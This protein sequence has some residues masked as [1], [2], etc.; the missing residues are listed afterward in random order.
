MTKLSESKGFS[1]IEL[2]TVIAI[3]AI[4][5]AIIFPVMNSVKDRANQTKCMTN[6]HDIQVAIKMYKLDNRTYPETLGIQYQDGKSFEQARP[7]DVELTIYM[8]QIKTAAAYRCP[9]SQVM[10]YSL[11]VDVHYPPEP[12]PSGTPSKTLTLYAVDSYDTQTNVSAEPVQAR[13]TLR[14]ADSIAQ[15]GTLAAHAQPDSAE[16]QESDFQRQLFLKAPPDDTVVT[17]CTYHRGNNAIVLFLDGHVSTIPK[18]EVGMSLWRTRP[19]K[20]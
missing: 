19:K 9:S 8:D 11:P 20:L 3:I 4:L 6:L 16:L 14:W 10:D 5:A 13:Y 15:V 18:A 7:T 1:L 2:L 12:S 17:W